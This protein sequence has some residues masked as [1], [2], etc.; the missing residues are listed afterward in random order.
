MGLTICQLTDKHALTQSHTHTHT[1]I[2]TYI[3]T[4]KLFLAFYNALWLENINTI[5]PSILQVSHRRYVLPNRLQ[6]C[7]LISENQASSCW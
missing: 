6:T 5:F 2:H 1:L 3:Q 4:D 7:C